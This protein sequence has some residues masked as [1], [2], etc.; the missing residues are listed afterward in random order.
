MTEKWNSIESAPRDGSTIR[1]CRVYNGRVTF[2]G[3]AAWRTVVFP[4]LN[5]AHAG[6]HVPAFEAT[7]WMY[8]DEAKRVPEPTHWLPA[9][10]VV[11]A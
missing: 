10:M 11:A 9:E 2:E 5:V 6:L 1:Y 7:G 8:P 4:E 3:R